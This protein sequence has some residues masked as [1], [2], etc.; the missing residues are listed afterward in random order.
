[1]GF[2]NREP[3]ALQEAFGVTFRMM[4][5]E[6]WRQ[7]VDFAK[8]R[9]IL[10]FPVMLALFSL[11]L[12]VGLRFLTGEVLIDPDSEQQAFSWDQLKF[13]L[14]AGM[15]M[16][17]LSMGSFAFIGR[18]MVSQ[19][20]G[21][22][23]YLL[24]SPAMQPL[25][26]ATNYFAYYVKEVCYYILLLLTPTVVG[27]AMGIMLESYSGLSTPLEWASLPVVFIALAATLT[28]GLALSFLAS[29][30]FSRGGHWTWTIPAVGIG[31]ALLFAL[32]VLPLQ[33]LILG[34]HYQFTHAHWVPLIAFPL[35]FGLAFI[36]SHLVPADFEVHVSSKTELYGP[37]HSRLPF[38]GSGTLR[39]LVAKDLV[40]LWRSRTLVK[41]LVS[42]TV[43]LLFL[44]L[45]A[46][47]VDFAAFPIPFNLLSYAPFLGFF[48][49]QFYSWLNGMD[50]PD[51]LNGLPV[52]VPQLLRAKVVV[53]FLI[54]TW[55][56]V[57]FLIAMG[58]MLDQVWALPAALIVML[59][60]SI[61]IVSLTAFLMGLR[62][63]KAI[64]DV[65]IMGW[66][67]LGTIV[68]LLGLFLLSFTQGDMTIYENWGEQ[69]REQ[70]L[71]ATT[72][73][74][75]EVDD[76]PDPARGLKGILLVSAA[77]TI[78]GLAFQLMLSRR[79][80]RAAFEN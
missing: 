65:S 74:L 7:N 19:R 62:P 30:L 14:H 47:L 28:Q 50:P 8:R 5:R 44:L 78:L 49:F 59:A 60:N 17:A 68:P 16:F 18:V 48:G 1:M 15:F 45:L 54:T 77:I 67:Y 27:M 72:A 25:D 39:I 12:T 10:M 52:S 58:V 43:P 66:F 34:M 24:A 76:N 42:F 57:L 51:F 55:I 75:V 31:T 22:K 29:A 4:F 33:M 63:N 6:E 41:M 32:E 37:I 9:N 64:F 20:A 23:N 73:V 69:V 40:D 13:F 36:G 3:P 56:S 53:Y 79:W 11:I 71:N 46:W 70:G 35:A 38:L 21:G 2:G 80:G 61:Y 26:L